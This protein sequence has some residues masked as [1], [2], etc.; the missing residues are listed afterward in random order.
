MSCH[1]LISE[2]GI[3]VASRTYHFFA[4]DKAC[5]IELHQAG[6]ICLTATTLIMRCIQRLNFR[7]PLSFPTKMVGS[8]KLWYIPTSAGQYVFQCDR[9][10]DEG[11]AFVQ[12]GVVLCSDDVTNCSFANFKCKV[13][14]VNK[15]IEVRGRRAEI[16]FPANMFDPVVKTFLIF[17]PAIQ[18]SRLLIMVLL[19]AIYNSWP[20]LD[21]TRELQAIASNIEISPDMIWIEDNCIFKE[22]VYPS[23]WYVFETENILFHFFI[24]LYLLYIV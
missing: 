6:V 23:Y 3:A 17:N 16:E 8:A 14:N 13:A 10:L 24:T 12:A 20:A 1:L 11:S 4:G 15:Q 9:L 7:H 18:G 5:E 22:N 21:T 2:V 19:R